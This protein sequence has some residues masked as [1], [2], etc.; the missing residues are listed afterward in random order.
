MGKKVGDWYHYSGAIHMHTTAS[1]GTAEIEQL[2][3]IGRSCGLDFMMVTDHMTQ[4]HRDNGHEGIYG[5][6]LVLIGYE[7]ND[8]KD[9]NHYLLFDA[10]KVYPEEWPARDYVAA[11]KND[12]AIGII[13]HPDETRDK[14]PQYPPYPWTEWEADGFTGVELWNQMSEWM[15]RLTHWNKLLMSLSPRKSMI[16]PPETTLKRWDDWNLKRKVV[17]IAGVDAHEFP[18]SVRPFT[19]K[20]FPYKVHFRCLRTHIIL[21][22]PMS[23]G[24]D[25]ARAQLYDA[26][27]DCRVYCSNMRWGA[28]DDFIFTAKSGAGLVCSGG[29]L[30][31]VDHAQLHVRLPERAHIN[32]IHNG[33][34]VV[35]VDTTDLEYGVQKPGIYRVE[36]WKG[37]RGW[38]FSNH[39]RIGEWQQ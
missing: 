5:N 9:E 30:P 14:L 2:I 35:S 23:E 3:D 34:T 31:S 17:G 27:R 16:G 13:A 1:D 4:V 21:P 20:I 25:T 38:I 39:I 8:P 29:E 26:F 19:L 28:A 7:H 32:I 11:A 18:V 37:T 36:A 15:E 22:E 10:P 33:R 12:N 24:F 6:T